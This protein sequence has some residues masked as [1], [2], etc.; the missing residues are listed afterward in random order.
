MFV[1]GANLAAFFHP[2]ADVA[3]EHRIVHQGVNLVLASA[4]CLLGSLQTDHVAKESI[5]MAEYVMG[6][7]MRIAAVFTGGVEQSR[8]TVDGVVRRDTGCVT[9]VPML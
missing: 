9:Q 4:N 3:M 6:A 1:L 2:I 7:A 8:V 5:T